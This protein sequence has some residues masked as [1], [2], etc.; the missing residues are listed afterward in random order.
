MLQRY[1]QR[2][3]GRNQSEYTVS[4]STALMESQDLLLAPGSQAS[5]LQPRVER[6]C[7]NAQYLPADVSQ[8]SQGQS[9]NISAV[10][11]GEASQGMK[12]PSNKEMQVNQ[13]NSLPPH[14][15]V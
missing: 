14:A 6:F 2:G 3:R 4:I 9:A 10:A 12:K 5:W 15:L 13:A 1:S 7:I 11:L 8:Q